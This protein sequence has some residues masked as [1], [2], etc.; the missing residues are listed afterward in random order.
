MLDFNP[1]DVAFP[2]GHYIDGVVIS[3]GLE[4]LAVRRPSDNK[5]YADLSIGCPEIVDRAVASA[6]RAFR[7]TSWA[8]GAPRER[9]RILR[10][11]AD[12]IEGHAIELGRVEALGSTRPITDIIA[13]DLPY[14]ADCIRFF[15]EYADKLGG[16]IA[17]TRT[18]NLGMV[19]SEPYGVV[20]AISPW[21]FPVNQAVTKIGP[22][23]AAGN[24][25]VLKPSEMTPFSAV[26]LAQLGTEAGMPAGI[27]NV[28]QGTGMATGDS[29]CRHPGV[30]KISFTGST[31]TGAAIMVASAES[32]LKPVTLELGGKS[33]QLVF[34]DA[35]LDKVAR[36][37]A[38]SIFGNAGQ[39]CV[40]GSRLIVER[41]VEDELVDRVVRLS[42]A[43][44]PGPTWSSQT[45]FSPI[46]STAQLDRIDGMVRRTLDAG[47]EAL[48]GGRRLAEIQDGAFYEP[49]ILTHVTSEMEA[50]REEV[51]GPV[52]TS[53]SFDD[54]EEGLNLASHPTYGLAAGVHTAD[55]GKAM[56]AVRS[57][58]AGTVWVNRYGRTADYI[59][60]TGGYNGSGIGKDLG[61]QA[62]EANMRLKS[63]LI[64]FA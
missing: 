13:V 34:A 37:I 45:S 14:A 25:V 58:K 54:E 41:R 56:R 23:L 50:V 5:V 61:R 46:V 19:I 40:A 26:R 51:F 59:I 3:D 2:N 33:P 53:Q 10:R 7:K 64:D 35:D 31:R 57:I 28:V 49:T 60:P 39:V 20:A 48:I 27:F 24:A 30:G 63:A 9:A 38:K 8:T 17:A 6:E 36:N 32:G 22:A 21:N 11:W 55:I 62:V 42:Q 29:L 47:A 18:D 44:Q 52:L 16:D 4:H 43:M 15:A 1:D 12:L